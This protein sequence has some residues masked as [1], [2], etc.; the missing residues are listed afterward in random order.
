MEQWQ[1][2]KFGPKKDD[3]EVCYTVAIA[4]LPMI[5][6]RNVKKFIKYI[7]KLEGFQGL[8][9][10]YPHGTLLIFDTENHAKAA[11]NLI[12]NYPGYEGGI[13]N[14]IGEIFVNKKYLRGQK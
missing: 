3:E 10:Y 13:G 2:P 11:R 6:D 1:P 14:N 8:Y 12:K 5:P 4:N 7:E 9:P